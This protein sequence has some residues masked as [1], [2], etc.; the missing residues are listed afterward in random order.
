[1]N[2]TFSFYI[3]T[4][5][6]VAVSVFVYVKSL[7][8]EKPIFKKLA[9]ALIVILSSLYVYNLSQ[10]PHIINSQVVINK[11]YKLDT[12]LVERIILENKTRKSKNYKK[13]IE[14][15]DKKEIDKLCK[16]LKN[17]KKFKIEQ[18]PKNFAKYDCYLMLTDGDLLEFPIKISKVYGLYIEIYAPGNFFYE[19]L[20]N[21]KSDSLKIWV[22]KIY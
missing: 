4:I 20:G 11:Y 16:S 14:I 8:L 21:Y 2:F 7:K 3:L 9:I 18:A 1:M 6:L 12:I 13:Q 19:H 22:E 17:L 10:K 15:T 5:G